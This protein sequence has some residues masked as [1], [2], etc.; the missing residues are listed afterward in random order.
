MKINKC[1]H[2]NSHTKMKTTFILYALFHSQNSSE[3]LEMLSASATFLPEAPNS[4]PHLCSAAYCNCN[5][6]SREFIRFWPYQDCGY[7]NAHIL[8]LMHPLVNS[9]DAVVLYCF[10]VLVTMCHQVNSHAPN[11][12][13]WWWWNL[14][15]KRQKQIHKKNEGSYWKCHC[16]VAFI[17]TATVSY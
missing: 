7:A 13:R 14:L 3:M 6:T 2:E 8:T 12:R 16:S 11:A 5:F 1:V 17:Q 10:R 15:L 4:F 9:H